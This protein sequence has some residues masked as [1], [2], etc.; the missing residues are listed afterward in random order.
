MG[1]AQANDIFEPFN[2]PPLKDSVAAVLTDGIQARINVQGEISRKP[3]RTFNYT[4]QDFLESY[5]GKDYTAKIDLH[6]NEHNQ[7][8]GFH[9]TLK[10]LFPDKSPY[11]KL[12]ALLEAQKRLVE[13]FGSKHQDGQA[14]DPQFAALLEGPD[15]HQLCEDLLRTVDRQHPTDEGRTLGTDIQKAMSG[16]LGDLQQQGQDKFDTKEFTKLYEKVSAEYEDVLPKPEPG[17]P[18]ERKMI[19]E[20]KAKV[21]WLEQQEAALEEIETAF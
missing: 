12:P 15:A 21:E 10:E 20:T 17:E 13:Y 11:L 7:T 6:E 2:Y 4:E 18:G 1:R 14:I 19:R 3:G 8:F 9:E 16:F 5:L